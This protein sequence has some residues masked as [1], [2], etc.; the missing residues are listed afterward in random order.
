MIPSLVFIVTMSI[1]GNEQ[2][3]ESLYNLAEHITERD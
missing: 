1:Y 2:E 3:F